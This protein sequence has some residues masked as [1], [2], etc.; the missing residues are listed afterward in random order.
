[1]NILFIY[2]HPDLGYSIGK[3][4][5]PIEEE[6]RKYAEVDALYLPVQNYSLMGLCRN[7]KAARKVTKSKDYDV[8]NI[9]GTEN[10]LIPFM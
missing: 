8:I 9:T 2:R 1:M 5:K 6:M 3:V 7:I 4:F 10:Y